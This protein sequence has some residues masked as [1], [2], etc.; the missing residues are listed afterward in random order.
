MAGGPYRFTFWSTAVRH[1]RY[2]PK[3]T[4]KRSISNR[5]CHTPV[6]LGEQGDQPLLGV[7]TLEILGLILNPFSRELQPMRML[8]A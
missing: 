5:K 7:V 2:W 1:T 6:I 4:G 8:L 3:M